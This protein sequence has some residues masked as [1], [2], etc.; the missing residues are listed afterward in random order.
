MI[1]HSGS[2]AIEGL[3]RVM[4]PVYRCRIALPDEDELFGNDIRSWLE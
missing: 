4:E 1:R 2:S 3:V